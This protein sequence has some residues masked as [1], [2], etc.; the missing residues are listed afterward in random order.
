MV[1]TWGPI[2]EFPDYAVSSYGNVVDL[3]TDKIKRLTPNFQG[4]L[5]VNME[6]DG[7][8]TTRSVAILAAKAFVF[9]DRDNFDTLIHLDGNKLNCHV[10]N[11]AWRPRWFSVKYHRQ[12]LD[13]TFNKFRGLI[14]LPKTDEIFTGF[15]TPVTK[16][17]LLWTSIRKSCIEGCIV[18][19]TDQQ[20]IFLD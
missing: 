10:D 2:E 6:N 16:Y 7:V 20:F 13:E 8:W 4:I 18:F 15:K 12:F 19:P 3:R 5:K 14:A 17:G 1:E 9:C 11:L